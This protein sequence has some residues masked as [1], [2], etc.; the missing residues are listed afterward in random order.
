MVE[1]SFAILGVFAG[2]HEPMILFKSKLLNNFFERSWAIEKIV[3]KD[4]FN[5]LSCCLS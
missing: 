5:K 3:E 1:K 2:R 4:Y